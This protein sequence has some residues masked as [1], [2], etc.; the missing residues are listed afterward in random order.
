MTNIKTEFLALDKHLSRACS[1]LQATEDGIQ[2]LTHQ[3]DDEE[4]VGLLMDLDT[5]VSNYWKIDNLRDE[6]KKRLI[7]NVKAK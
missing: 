3:V 4:L 2:S 7:V 6:I 5:E 1:E